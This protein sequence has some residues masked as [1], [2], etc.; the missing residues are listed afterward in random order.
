MTSSAM[1]WSMLGEWTR[2]S[3]VSGSVSREFGRGERP[4]ALLP[5]VHSVSLIEAT[6]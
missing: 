5:Y 6:R 1:R 4:E 2:D 3:P